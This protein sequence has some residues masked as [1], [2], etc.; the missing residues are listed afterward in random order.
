MLCYVM[1]FATKIKIIFGISI[2]NNDGISKIYV[3][4]QVALHSLTFT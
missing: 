2:S 1:L 3:E 4:K